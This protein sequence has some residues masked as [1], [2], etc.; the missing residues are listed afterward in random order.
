MVKKSNVNKLG[1]SRSRTRVDADKINESEDP[2]VNLWKGLMRAACREEGASERHGRKT[3][4]GHSLRF[5]GAGDPFRQG[6]LP[7]AKSCGQVF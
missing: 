3:Q 2:R 5:T 6:A 4:G 7:H 1:K